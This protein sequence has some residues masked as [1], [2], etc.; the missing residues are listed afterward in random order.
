Q[1]EHRRHA[2]SLPLPLVGKGKVPSI[3]RRSFGRSGQGP[4]LGK[5]LWLPREASPRIPRFPGN[6]GWHFPPHGCSDS[7][8]GARPARTATANVTVCPRE[9]LPTQRKGTALFIGNAVLFPF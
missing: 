9:M 1:L 5:V 4:A 7:A 8:N 6:D 3:N 2:V